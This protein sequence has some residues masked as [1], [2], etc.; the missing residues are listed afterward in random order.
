MDKKAVSM[1]QQKRRSTIV[2]VARAAGVSPMTVSNV[3][4]GREGTVSAE[5]RERVEREIHRLK[6]RRMASARALRASV[7]RTI[8]M[9]IVDDTPAFL[10]DVFTSQ[11]VAGLANVLNSADYTLTLQGVRC[12]ELVGSTITRFDAAAGF[13]AMLAGSRPQREESARLLAAAPF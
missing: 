11:V 13:C 10:A 6:Y 8:G 12:G 2:D 3:L 9:V 4:N 7:Q 1:T 5:T